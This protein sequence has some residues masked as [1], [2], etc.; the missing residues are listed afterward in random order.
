MKFTQRVQCTR[1]RFTIE[2][3]S[4]GAVGMADVLVGDAM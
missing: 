3:A 2:L 4:R 1:L